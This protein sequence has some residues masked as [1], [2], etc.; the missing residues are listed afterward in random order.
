MGL[1]YA[2]GRGVGQQNALCYPLGLDHGLL[3]CQVHGHGRVDGE[4][5][6]SAGARERREKDVKVGL[7]GCPGI[8]G[9]SEQ[10]LSARGGD[11]V[12]VKA[13]RVCCVVQEGM[14]VSWV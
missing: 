9:E 6:D 7:V 4:D 3:C 5:V 14:K 8:V 1:P 12:G 11:D 2:L 13:L 10:L